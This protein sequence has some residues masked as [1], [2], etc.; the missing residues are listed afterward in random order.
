VVSRY[1]H[2]YGIKSFKVQVLAPLNQ[3]LIIWICFS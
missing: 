3:A 2:N 1:E